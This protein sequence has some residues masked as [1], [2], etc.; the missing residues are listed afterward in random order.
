MLVALLFT[1]T[2]AEIQLPSWSFLMYLLLIISFWN[3]KPPRCQIVSGV[4]RPYKRYVAK[5]V[6]GHGNVLPKSCSQFQIVWKMFFFSSFWDQK[7]Q[8]HG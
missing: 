3:L 2:V 6:A 1:N 5:N 8:L 4:F 7:R